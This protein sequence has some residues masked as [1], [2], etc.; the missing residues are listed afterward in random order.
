[1]FHYLSLLFG[2]ISRK[3]TGT[4]PKVCYKF[5]STANRALL[6]CSIHHFVPQLRPLEVSRF[7]SRWRFSPVPPI[8]RPGAFLALGFRRPTRPASVPSGCMPLEL[9]LLGSSVCTIKIRSVRVCDP[10]GTVGTNGT[11]T[12][13]REQSANGIAFRPLEQN[14]T[15]TCIQKSTP[16]FHQHPSNGHMCSK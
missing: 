11:W 14:P 9:Q 5:E 10:A 7:C 12:A 3:V 13:C 4:H 8:G 16:D 1:V 6:A 15:E 2:P